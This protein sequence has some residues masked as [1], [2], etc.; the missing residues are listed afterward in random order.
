MASYIKGPLPCGAVTDPAPV[1]GACPRQGGVGTS[2]GACDWLLHVLF[3]DSYTHIV[4]APAAYPDLTACSPGALPVLM[5]HPSSTNPWLLAVNI[6]GQKK[7]GPRVSLGILESEPHPLLHSDR[8]VHASAP[9]FPRTLDCWPP[10][11]F[12]LRPGVIR[13][14]RHPDSGIQAPRHPDFQSPVHSS[15]LAR[16]SALS[17][18]SQ[19]HFIPCTPSPRGPGQE[20]IF[21]DVRAGGR[22]GGRVA[23]AEAGPSCV[24]PAPLPSAPRDGHPP[25]R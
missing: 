1:S 24:T 17:R 13:A 22:S 15:P 2:P 23:G 11:S 3:P 14:P 10:V 12:S 7:K 20:G 19:P 8:G 5:L 21:Q 6:L 25:P 4:S 18:G 16:P 9:S